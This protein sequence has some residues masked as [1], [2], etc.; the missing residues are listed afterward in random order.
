MLTIRNKL[1]QSIEFQSP[2]QALDF[3]QRLRE[4]AD[5]VLRGSRTVQRDEPGFI[6]LY[7]P[8]PAHTVPSTTTIRIHA[9]PES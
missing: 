7:G 3:A 1:D 9:E 5:E 6:L 2:Q 4:L 8:G